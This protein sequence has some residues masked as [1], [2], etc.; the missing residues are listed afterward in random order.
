MSQWNSA[1]WAALCSGVACPICRRG[2]PDGIVLELATSYLTS[3]INAPMRGYCC[4][5]LKRHAVELH[6][7]S[8]EEAVAF[9]RDV[10]RVSRA[11]HELTRPVKLNYEIHGNTIP[12]LHM[13]LYPR[14]RGDP[15]EGRAI[16]PKL[17]KVS[18]YQVNEF[19]NFVAELRAR[20]SAV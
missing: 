8:D 10:Q 1:E 14:H 13:H 16:D 2:K 7:L 3:S 6:E 20:M 17:I 18:P 4:V 19:A 9:T 5:V 15:F 11:I 12:H